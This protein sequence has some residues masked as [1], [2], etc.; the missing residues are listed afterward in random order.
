V[1]ELVSA[2]APAGLATRLDHLFQLGVLAVLVGILS[3]AMVMQFAFGEIPCP[4]CL[5][6]RLAMFGVG[7]TILQGF[8]NGFGERLTG[9]GLLFALL[10]LAIATRQTLLDIAPRPGHAYIGSAILGLHMP[11]W[12]VV[13]ALALLLSYAL[14]IAVLGAD[15]SRAVPLPAISLAGRVLGLALLVLCAVNL[16]A[17][18]L[19]CGLGECH[20]MGYRLLE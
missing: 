19:Q 10:L 5:L 14:K 3:A 7:F 17:V 11:V 9:L 8:R 18:V 2:A 1:A 4:L 16:G 20:T 15:P 13:I 6:E 12:S